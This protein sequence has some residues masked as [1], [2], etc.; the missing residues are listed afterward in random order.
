MPPIRAVVEVDPARR[1]QW[2]MPSALRYVD[3]RQIRYLLP[4][5]ERQTWAAGDLLL[6]EVEGPPGLIRSIQN[7]SRRTPL[8]YRE[9]RLFP[10]SKLV[11]VLAPRAGSSTCIA[12][13][14][15][16][17]VERL[18]LHG[19]G[20]Q[21]GVVDPSSQHSSLYT[22]QLTTISVLAELGDAKRRRL[23]MRRFAID[24][25]DEVRPRSPDD[26]ALVLVVGSDMDSGKTTTARRIVYA[27]RAMGHR[28]A[29]GKATGVA[30]LGDLTSLYD[31]GATEVLDFAALGEPA[32][33][34]LPEAEVRSIF[35][36]LANHLVAAAGPRGYVVME[37]ADGIWYRETRILLEDPHVR[38]AVTHMVFACHSILD[39]E[40]GLAMLRGLGYGDKL[41]ALSGKLGSS[42]MLRDVAPTLLGPLPVFD[43][44]DYA[45]SPEGL[46]R[47][48]ATPS[49]ADPGAAAR[50]L[51]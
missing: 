13:V 38:D 32:T 10:G 46:V 34:G 27:L 1:N 33:I 9:T 44:T 37:L 23:T 8:N 21:A 28:V 39:A 5:D 3:P 40:N 12:R 36:R 22:G 25:S 42:G 17:P 35:H 47:L 26:P 30:S 6:A 48:F 19:V 14:P 24:V 49:T 29:A 18:D 11:V 51:V 4:V 50:V 43:P 31:A 7:T 41:R 16:R 20:G 2:L 15:E 45:T